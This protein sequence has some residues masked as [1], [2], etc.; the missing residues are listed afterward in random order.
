MWTLGAACEGTHKL[1]PRPQP[2][3]FTPFH[4]LDPTA[5]RFSQAHGRRAAMHASS[6]STARMRDYFRALCE[7]QGMP[8][9]LTALREQCGPRQGTSPSSSSSSSSSPSDAAIVL[10]ERFAALQQRLGKA[11]PA[12]RMTRRVP[13]PAADPVAAQERSFSGTHTHHTNSGGES[14]VTTTSL[15][16]Q[17]E[18]WGGDGA[19]VA[20]TG[21]AD[22]AGGELDFER[23]EPDVGAAFA[24]LVRETKAACEEQVQDE[25]AAEAEG[26]NWEALR[27]RCA[28]LRDTLAQEA[29]QTVDA[30][31]NGK[32]KARSK[33]KGSGNGSAKGNG[34]AK[35]GGKSKTKG[36]APSKAAVL[37]AAS[38]AATAAVQAV[39]AEGGFDLVRSKNSGKGT[40]KAGQTRA[41]ADMH[42]G[43]Q[44]EKEIDEEDGAA[45]SDF[46]YCSPRRSPG[47]RRHPAR[48]PGMDVEERDAKGNRVLELL[49]ELRHRGVLANSGGDAVSGKRPARSARRRPAGARGTGSGSGTGEARQFLARNVRSWVGSAPSYSVVQEAQ[50]TSR[51]LMEGRRNPAGLQNSRNSPAAAAAQPPAVL[52]PLLSVPV[53][54]WVQERGT[55]QHSSSSQQK[56]CGSVCLCVCV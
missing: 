26:H 15:A 42:S 38:A 8:R 33:A 44:A 56:V 36:K 16:M 54:E 55:P 29:K 20:W 24:Q 39:F 17:E 37:V 50:Q 41:K 1:P 23:T 9:G 28:A 48:Q 25:G 2:L 12:L 53:N 51:A 43:G 32:G 49:L 3:P 30:R 22:G 10:R 47:R 52:N 34:K 5:P 19:V 46:F 40:K 14:S 31:T 4:T 21:E 45:A 35:G 6:D 27:E 18:R 13:R 7:E 11:P